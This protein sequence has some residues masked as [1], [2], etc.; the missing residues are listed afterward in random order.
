MHTYKPM[1]KQQQTRPHGLFV[2]TLC[3]AIMQDETTGDNDVAVYAEALK[4]VRLYG[5]AAPPQTADKS[6][7]DH[8]QL[9]LSTSP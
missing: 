4:T 3:V 5:L 6:Q 7:P 8:S 1:R 2:S 9:N